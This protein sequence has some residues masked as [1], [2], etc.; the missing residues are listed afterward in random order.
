MS[1]SS[2][3]CGQCPVAVDIDLLKA[4]LA[5]ER[6]RDETYYNKVVRFSWED[7]QISKRMANYSQFFC[8]YGYMFDSIKNYYDYLRRGAQ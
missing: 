8:L 1:N 3:A 2:C 4:L 5:E 6:R 7:N